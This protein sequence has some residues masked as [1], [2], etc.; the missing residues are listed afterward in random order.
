MSKKFNTLAR[1]WQRLRRTSEHRADFYELLGHFVTDGLPLFEALRDIDLQYQ[2]T[3]QPMR[4]VTARVLRRLRGEAGR[5]Y[6]FGAALEGEVPVVEALAVASGE[7]AGDLAQGLYRAAM[8]C[9]NNGQ[10]AATMR[11]ELAYPVFLALMF[12]ALMMGIAFYVVPM[13][14]SVLPLERWPTAAR[15][16]ARLASAT[17][18]LLLTGATLVFGFLITFMLTRSHWTGPLRSRLDKWVF[19]WSLHRRITGALLMAA[20]AT[21]IRI[22]IPFSRTLERLAHT[23]GPWEAQHLQRMRARLRRG[24]REGAA[25][26]TDLFDDELRWQIELYGRMTHFSEGL[27]KLAARSVAQTQA[28]IRR[29]FAALRVLL[30]IGIAVLI[31]WIYGSFLTITMAARAVN[32]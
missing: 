23:S 20:I 17:P 4:H 6:T 25:L 28:A 13:L 7:E 12:A 27:E 21:L 14:S 11:Q 16:M 10:I 29:A 1:L 22:G 19:P 18:W 24:E 15:W 5:A 8:V 2:R 30:M 9:R 26:A 32:G 3:G 31:A